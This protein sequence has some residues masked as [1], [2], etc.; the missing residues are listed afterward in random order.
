MRAKNRQ[1][2]EE[3]D[4]QFLNFAD[5]LSEDHHRQKMAQKT[6]RF[7]RVLRNG[8]KQHKA[9]NWLQENIYDKIVDREDENIKK[10]N[11]RTFDS[12]PKNALP[13]HF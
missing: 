13:N 8:Q 11:R 10:G 3:N 9:F 1:E 7:D 2:E 6:A 4:Q 5:N 12:R